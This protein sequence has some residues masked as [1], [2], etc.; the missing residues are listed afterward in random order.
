MVEKVTFKPGTMLNPVPVVM[1]S[2]GKYDINPNIITLAWAGTVCSD[3]PML[4]ISLR[5]QRFSY[6]IIKE[7]GFFVVN[8]VDGNLIRAADWCGVKSGRDFNKFQQTGLTPIKA[9]GSDCCMIEQSPVNIE[10]EVK[11][12]IPLGTHDMFLAEVKSV[13]VNACLIDKT[14]RLDLTKADLS[15]YSHGVYHKLGHETGT[16][17]F[18]V[19]KINLKK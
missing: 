8:L 7:S 6:D 19:K 13:H 2:C 11:Q 16:F 15:V 9:A 12:I 17:G 5:K 4:S 14:G 10:C 1:V 3:P 18:S